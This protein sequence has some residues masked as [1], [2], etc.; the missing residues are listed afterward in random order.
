ML[1]SQ[2]RIMAFVAT[3]RPES[4]L[5]FYRDVLGLRLLEDSPFALVFDSHDIMLRVQKVKSLT[6]HM[7]TS[8]GWTV[9]DIRH[10]I[11]E[12]QQK[13]VE[14]QRYPGLQQDTYGVWVSPA[15]ARVAWFKDPDG[16]I[17]SLTQF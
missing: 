2:A 16:N 5:G 9:S 10:T 17:L 1:D 15:G 13:G 14:F 6:P 12:L 4:A 3:T 11:S 8:L 7:H